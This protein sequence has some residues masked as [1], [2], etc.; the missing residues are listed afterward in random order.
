MVIYLSIYLSIYL[1]AK[2]IGNILILKLNF[3]E[4]LI[5]PY[6]NLLSKAKIMKNTPS[7]KLYDKFNKNYYL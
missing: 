1:H 4:T 3:A 7:P 2:S 6:S 5:L